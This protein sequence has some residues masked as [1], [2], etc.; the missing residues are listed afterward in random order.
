MQETVQPLVDALSGSVPG[1]LGALAI[2]VVG[3]IVAAGLAAATRG[4]LRRTQLDERMAGWL[5]AERA[6]RDG[7]AVPASKGVFFVVALI[8]VVGALQVLGLTLV[9]EPINGFL[10]EVVGFLPRV[11]GAG[12]LLLVA[13]ILARVARALVTGA[14]SR[15]GVDDRFREESGREAAPVSASI[16]E[17]S[18]WIVLLLFL[19]AVVGVLG[20]DGVLAPLRGM[21]G[22]LLGVLP[23]LL[24]AAI[25]LAVGWF[26]ARV[27][28]RVV[29]GLTAS[30]G[31]DRVAERAGIAPREGGMRTSDLL[32]L[33][34]Y[35]LVL[36]PVILAAL[37]TLELDALTAPT[38][39]LLSSLMGAIPS[40]L[41]ATLIVSIGYVVGKV[42]API[43]SGILAGAGFDRLPAAIG[44]GDRASGRRPW[45][46]V[47]GT[48]V[49]VAVVLFAAIEAAEV[50]GFL[51]LGTAL[52]AIGAFAARALVGLVILLVGMFL[53]GVVGG[54][55]DGSRLPHARVLGGVAR[56]AVLLVAGAM[57]LTEAGLATEVVNLTF[58]L[59]LGAVAVA[60][61]L[62]FGLGGREAA[63]RTLADLRE[64]RS[65]DPGDTRPPMTH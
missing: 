34:T 60:A 38:T 12:L 25:I 22:E 33:V 37:H 14:L 32:G 30:A 2:L 62:A 53:A 15:A 10:D 27:L 61:A 3:W 18:Q 21:T 51:A 26:L 54:A 58:G 64:R 45:S 8:S 28:R 13:W 56:A 17:A 65:A 5:G 42:L 46:Q 40:L 24:G 20:M 47:A 36:I 16:G 55:V 63:A 59:L 57:A 19:P 35:G 9:T 41:A 7:V 29:A 23:N 52:A 39:A 50:L 1:I 6:A 11:L 31:V 44:L 4:L 49:L 43:V 48:V